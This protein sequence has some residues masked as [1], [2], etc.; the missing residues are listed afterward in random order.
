MNNIIVNRA[1]YLKTIKNYLVGIWILNVI[2][3]L[4]TLFLLVVVRFGEESNRFMQN[5]V[6]KPILAMF[7]KIIVIGVMLYFMYY[8]ASYLATRYLRWTV[9]AVAMLFIF[10]TYICINNL[11]VIY[12]YLRLGRIL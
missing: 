2:D 1:N 8:V 3:I 4:S 9:Y 10:Y 11:Y 5:I 12:L 6:N 7:V